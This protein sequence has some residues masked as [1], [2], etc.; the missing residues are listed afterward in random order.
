LTGVL[1]H[2]QPA[3]GDSPGG[4]LRTCTRRAADLRFRGRRNIT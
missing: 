3:A 1:A 4:G 2:Y